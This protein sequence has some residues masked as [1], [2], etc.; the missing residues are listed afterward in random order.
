MLI[1]AVVSYFF[2]STIPSGW[3][4]LVALLLLFSGVQLVFMGVLGTYIGGI[5]EEVKGRPRYIVAESIQHHARTFEPRR[6][7]ILHHG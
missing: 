6:E 1:V 2:D 5:Y 7:E 3:T 4:T